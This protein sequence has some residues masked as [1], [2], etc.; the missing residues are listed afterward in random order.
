MKYRH[1]PCLLAAVL[2]YLQARPG[3]TYVDATI[4]AAGHAGEI[5]RRGR[6]EP[7]LTQP[8]ARQAMLERLL[9]LLGP[10]ANSLELMKI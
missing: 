3:G 1:E 9:K 6:G 2:H 4:G 7:M 10:P 8:S 5:A